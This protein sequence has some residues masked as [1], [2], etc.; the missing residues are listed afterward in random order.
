VTRQELETCWTRLRG[1]FPKWKPTD[2]EQEVWLTK[3]IGHNVD[4][5][6]RSIEA[7]YAGKHFNDP[8]LDAVLSPLRR[9][10]KA[11]VEEDWEAKVRESI[12]QE[13]RA[14]DAEL[15]AKFSAED[16][17]GLKAAV[18]EH[19]PDRAWMAKSPATSRPWRDLLHQ[20]FIKGVAIVYMEPR[21]EKRPCGLAS[22]V[23]PERWIDRD[24][25]W[26]MQWQARKDQEA[27]EEVRESARLRAAAAA[28][29]MATIGQAM[30]EI[31]GGGQ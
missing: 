29:G 20:R 30:A 19:D 21:I 12:V 24:E 23:R 18:L 22:M 11:Q 9:G 8:D 6:L 27:A 5:V 25:Y 4:D 13:T 10:A 31:A 15:D 14:I 1:L 17:A 2:P 26:L 3:L 16:L 28:A 7:H